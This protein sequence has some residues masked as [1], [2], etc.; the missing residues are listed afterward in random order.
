MGLEERPQTLTAHW[1]Q[2]CD[3]CPQ[4]AG[5]RGRA[6]E[7]WWCLWCFKHC[8]SRDLSPERAE[9]RLGKG[10]GEDPAPPPSGP[11]GSG[12]VNSKYR[13]ENAR[14]GDAPP[15]QWEEGGQTHLPLHLPPSLC[16]SLPLSHLV[17][18]QSISLPPTSSLPKGRRRK[19][20]QGLGAWP[21]DLTRTRSF[22]PALLQAVEETACRA[23]WRSG[24]GDPAGTVA[25]RLGPAAA[26]LAAR[27]APRYVGRGWVAGG[28]AGQRPPV[29]SLWRGCGGEPGP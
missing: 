23:G 25:T 24:H 7:A 16:F 27:M 11:T 29:L 26:G 4:P 15:P 10:S 8:G 21:C 17:S 5:W 18:V 2:Q 19:G 12:R 22:P 28:Q 6:V 14:D 20:G 13:D 3:H 9:G 1:G